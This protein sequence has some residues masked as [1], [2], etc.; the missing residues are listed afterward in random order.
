MKQVRSKIL[1]LIF[2]STLCLLLSACPLVRGTGNAVEATGEGIG[3][4]VI[5]T[6][7]AIGQAGRELPATD[8][9]RGPA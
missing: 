3:D 1:N 4:A 8:D 2:L 5:G 9:R 7:Q 6:G